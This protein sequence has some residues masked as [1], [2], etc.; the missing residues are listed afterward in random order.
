MSKHTIKSPDGHLAL[1]FYVEDGR[2]AYDVRRDGD[3][4]VGLSRLGLVQPKF[5]F[6]EGLTLKKESCGEI[7]ETYKI[8]VFKKSECVNHCNTIALELEKEGRVMVVEGRAYDDGAALRMILKGRGNGEICN[9]ITEF[10]LPG[11]INTVTA[12]KYLFTYE[13]QYQPVP[14][15]DLYQNNYAFPVL[16][17]VRGN[18]WAFLAEAGVFGNYG[19]SNLGSLRGTPGVLR[20][21]KAPDKLDTIKAKYPMETPWRVVYCGTLDQ[22]VNGNLLENLNPESIVE[23]PSYIKGGLAAWSWNAERRSGR[24]SKRQHD[25]VDLAAEFNWPYSVVDAGW[26]NAIDIAELC[27]YAAKKN[28][29]VWIWDH[30]AHLR[31]PEFVD[32]TFKEWAGWGVAG[33]KIDFFESDVQE[34]AGQFAMLAEKA[35]KYK[36][37]INF[38]GCMRPAGNSRVWP[39][40]LAYE[41]VMGAEFLSHISNFLPI[42]PDAPHNCTLPFT[43]NAMGPMDYTP[44]VYEAYDTGTTDVHQTALPVIFTAYITHM[45]EGKDVL[46]K[47]KCAQF[48]KG[49]PADW[50]ESHLLEGYPASYVTMAR[51]KGDEWAVAGI[52]ARRPHNAEVT[53]DFLECDK[54][55]AELYLDDLSDLFPVDAANGGNGEMTPEIVAKLESMRARSVLHHH[56]LKKTKIKKFVLKK[57]QTMVFPEAANGGFALRLRPKK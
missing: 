37:M 45:G 18:I 12:M 32:K 14:I 28:V 53:F 47:N 20:V 41:G 10:A 4:I 24:D 55:D 26:P 16:Y 34:R 50:D 15:E 43:R 40:V 8:P 1:S 19:G 29:K 46:E 33:M 39:H 2:I 57:G 31:D 51:R 35:A 44:V 38:H 54:Y 27:D 5:D 3:E 30:S 13:D 17:Q 9:E 36:L 49:L 6:T 48:L 42:G 56:D 52:C 22:I 21:L 25:Y 7:C 23:D 11:H